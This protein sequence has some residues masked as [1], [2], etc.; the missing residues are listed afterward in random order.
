MTGVFF[1]VAFVLFALALVAAWDSWPRVRP[2]M[3][4]AMVVW[5]LSSTVYGLYSC[6]TTP[7]TDYDDDPPEYTPYRP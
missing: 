6:A 7:P 1:M 5:M 2:W 3:L 4:G